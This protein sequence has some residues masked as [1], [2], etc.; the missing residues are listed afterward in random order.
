MGSF[1][2]GSFSGAL[3]CLGY[4]HQSPWVVGLGFGVALVWWVQHED[5][6]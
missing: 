3:L 5:I 4:W 6:D 1:A 2:L